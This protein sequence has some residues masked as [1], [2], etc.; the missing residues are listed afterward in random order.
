MPKATSRGLTINNILSS[1]T[2]KNGTSSYDL[3]TASGPQTIAHGLG[4]IPRI[5][6][7]QGTIASSTVVSEANGSY[8][9]T[10]NVCVY[11]VLVFSAGV[12]STVGFGNSN[13]IGLIVWMDAVGTAKQEGVITVD[14]TNITI[15]W[16]KTGAP[17]GTF[18]MKW[19]VD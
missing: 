1:I 17:V 3:T 12:L 8:D 5:V 13:T 7:I 9:G 14:A 19:H 18:S 4:R 2:K 10:T 11:R 16:T 15:T 6:Q